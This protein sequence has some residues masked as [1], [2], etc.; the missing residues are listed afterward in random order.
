MQAHNNWLTPALRAFRQR[1]TGTDS[2][3]FVTLALNMFRERKDLARPADMTVQTVAAHLVTAHYLDEPTGLREL[4]RTT[5]KTERFRANAYADRV[6]LELLQNTED[7]LRGAGRNGALLVRAERDEGRSWIVLEHDGKAFDAGDVDAFRCMYSSSKHADPDRIGQFGVGIKSILSVADALELHSGGFHLRFAPHPGLPDAPLFL[8]PVACVSRRSNVELNE[9]RGVHLRLRWSRGTSRTDQLVDRLLAGFAAESIA[10]LRRVQAVEAKGAIRYEKQVRKPVVKGLGRCTLSGPNRPAVELLKV[11]D[12]RDVEVGILA[13]RR[14]N[15]LRLR[16]A[17]GR[18]RHIHAYF[19]TSQDSGT[20][21]LLHGRFVLKDDRESLDI[22]TSKHR[23]E[24]VAVMQKIAA[25][26][27]DL[28]QLLAALPRLDAARLPSIVLGDAAELGVLLQ[29]FDDLDASAERALE[30]GMAP[31]QVLRC[32][33]ARKVAGL[34]L[35]TALDGGLRRGKELL[36]GGRIHDL[37]HAAIDDDARL[38]DETVARWLGDAPLARFGVPEAGVAQARRAFRS[39]KAE[40]AIGGVRPMQ[41]DDGRSAARV[42]LAVALHRAFAHADDGSGFSAELGPLPLPVTGDGRRALFF[43]PAIDRP[44]A[45]AIAHLDMGSVSVSSL[46]GI[47]DAD[48]ATVR[49]H[50]ARLGTVGTDDFAVLRQCNAMRRRARTATDHERLLRV[51]AVVARDA[52][53]RSDDHPLAPVW[54]RLFGLGKAWR[55]GD[56]AGRLA[57]I[58]VWKSRMHLPVLAGTWRPACHVSVRKQPGVPRT[59]VVDLDRVAAI[60]GRR[61]KAAKAAQFAVGLGAHPGVPLM[62]WV[63]LP[64]DDT[65]DREHEIAEFRRVVPAAAHDASL[66]GPYTRLWTGFF[67]HFGKLVRRK[68]DA[69]YIDAKVGERPHHNC[70]GWKAS[71]TAA[72]KACFNANDAPLPLGWA[73]LPPRLGKTAVRKLLLDGGWHEFAHVPLWQTWNLGRSANRRIGPRGH[74]PTMLSDELR[75]AAVLRA[76]VAP[77]ETSPTRLRAARDVYRIEQL[78]AD[79]GAWASSAARMLPLV[80]SEEYKALGPLTAD[81]LQIRSLA[82]DGDAD[83]RHVLRALYIVAQRSLHGLQDGAARKAVVAAHR[84]LWDAIAAR[85]G[86]R[87]RRVRKDGVLRLRQRL[88]DACHDAAAIGLVPASMA[89]PGD[90]PLLCTSPGGALAWRRLADARGATAAECAFYDSD[91]VSGHRRAFRDQLSF[92]ELPTNRLGLARIL[93][94]PVFA[95]EPSRFAKASGYG[96]ICRWLGRLVADLQPFVEYVCTT[97]P[98]S[99]GD[100]MKPAT[101]AERA[102]EAG[103]HAP[104]F[105]AVQSWP[106]TLAL[107]DPTGARVELPQTTDTPFRYVPRKG[108][109]TGVF[110][111][112]VTIAPDLAAAQR[113]RW[114]LDGP[115]SEALQ[116]RG[117]A[118]FLQNLLR[119]LDPDNVG[120][121]RGDPSLLELTGNVSTESPAIE[122][123]SPSS[124]E[125]TAIRLTEEVFYSHRARAAAIALVA[126]GDPDQAAADAAVRWTSS[127]PMRLL[128]QSDGKT[129]P[130]RFADVFDIDV[131]PGAAAIRGALE[132]AASGMTLFDVVL[133]MLKRSN[134]LRYGGEIFESLAEVDERLGASVDA[135][136]LPNAET[137]GPRLPTPP[138]GRAQRGASSQFARRGTVTGHLG[139]R[140]ARR[141]LAARYGHDAVVDVSTREAREAAV[142]ARRLPDDYPLDVGVSPGVDV[143]VFADGA[144]HPPIGFEVKSRVGH[145][146]LVFDWTGNEHERCRRAVAGE[147]SIWPLSAY[148]VLAISGLDLHPATSPADPAPT[149]HIMRGED[150][151]LAAQPQRF[152]VRAATADALT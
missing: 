84:Q 74:F 140:F 149:V 79:A 3:L 8:L 24:N 151:L 148:R 4:L 129:E 21:M 6:F 81:L 89:Q 152:S 65:G 139:E 62:L 102:S 39:V 27:G 49:G 40:A 98:A 105:I 72:Y 18:A 43:E 95:T 108:H 111:V 70:H 144:R 12:S 34:P 135:L 97:H 28:I 57:T 16:P 87:G 100:P 50:L 5:A 142:E 59:H 118:P 119:A 32:L 14:G 10:F 134:R 110:Y 117:H 61:A 90:L 147:A 113:L 52:Q 41:R 83:L 56:D 125:S 77:N 67:R 133:A 80:A 106:K 114:R 138:S 92:A 36:F 58:A 73:G 76:A 68:Y 93:D 123:P 69:R 25:H 33:L 145:G 31:G 101:F 86:I 46:Q 122:R 54:T 94:I 150:A 75:Q 109:R 116:S 115:L 141:W 136:A 47:A 7:A 78:P 104:V 137:V 26:V 30:H 22:A 126:A 48:I 103:L 44:R 130:D 13:E 132:D 35:F 107:R 127:K 128:G 2:G 71:D 42:A 1:L 131:L 38:P 23:R 124:G 88:A 82:P 91:P 66:D 64:W 96:A 51:L 55:A 19:P 15:R 120:E 143:L 121:L 45:E 29:R 53:I 37:W 17:E 9:R 85:L 20:S 60:L 99:G 112:N 63:C 11:G 146:T